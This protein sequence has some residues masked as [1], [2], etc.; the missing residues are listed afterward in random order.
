M[1]GMATVNGTEE[2]DDAFGAEKAGRAG[3]LNGASS[4][5]NSEPPKSC[6]G[7]C[8]VLSLDFSDFSVQCRV[9]L[10]FYLHLCSA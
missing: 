5:L 2:S 1:E 7:S 9:C 10:E 6:V 8:L 4:Q 3:V